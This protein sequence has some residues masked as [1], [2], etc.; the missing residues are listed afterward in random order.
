[1][2]R[3]TS[4]YRI[5][6]SEDGIISI[7]NKN[8]DLNISAYDLEHALYYRDVAR[9]EEEIV[10]FK[11]SWL[12][13]LKKP[14][15]ISMVTQKKLKIRVEQLRSWLILRFLVLSYELPAKSWIQ[16]LEKYTTR[17]IE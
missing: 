8:A 7:P 6:V 9:P 14:K 15:L 3:N 13:W 2:K 12:T 1:M 11:N 5:K 17:R 4:Q 10:E 16:W